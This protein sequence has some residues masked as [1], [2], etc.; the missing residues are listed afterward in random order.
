MVRALA[1]GRRV[2]VNLNRALGY[3]LA[4]HLPIA[5]LGLLPLV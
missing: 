1:L 4:I 5:V 2:A 3:T